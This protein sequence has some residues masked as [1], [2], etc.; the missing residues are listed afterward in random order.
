MSLARYTGVAF[1]LGDDGITIKIAP[2]ATVTVRREDT[3]ALASL[4]SD[5]DGSAGLTNPVTADEEGRFYFH[6]AGIEQGYRLIV[7]EAAS[8]G[9]EHTLRYVPMGTFNEVSN[10]ITTTGDLIVGGPS[11]AMSRKG[12]GTDGYP[13]SGLSGATDGLAYLP[14]ALGF[15]LVGGYLD[16]SAAGSPTS[17]LTVSIKTWSGNDPSDSEP[18]F[19]PFRSSTPGTGSLTYR[20]ITAA[21]SI[22]INSSALLGTVGGVAFR[23]WCVAFDDNGTVRLAIINCTTTSAGV[24]TGRDVTEIYPLGGWGIASATLEADTSDSSGVFYSSGASV[25]AKAYA[26]LG[27]GEWG[28]FGSPGGVYGLPNAG[29]WNQNPTRIQLFG[30][31]IPLPGQT[32]QVKRSASGLVATGTTTIPTDDTI[33]QSTEGDQYLSRTIT[34]TSAANPI[35]IASTGT[36]ATSAAGNNNLAMALFQDSIANALKSSRTNAAQNTNA[37]LGISALVL[38]GKTDEIT[39]KM[40]AGIGGV[41]TTTFNGQAALQSFGG[42]LDS[43]IECT[44]LMG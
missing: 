33:P 28:E 3:G 11:G 42:T 17:T 36:F 16:W 7:V 14:P 38:A 18:V 26:T 23:L 12:A 41:G 20:K 40:R 15:N 27:F 29:N 37:W 8:P 9:A 5:R 6:A 30:P 24:G 35:A 44:E 39:Y 10:P 25:S 13:L 31:G 34:P 43:F 2:F 22:T 21:T 4:F 1:V 32:V 19:I